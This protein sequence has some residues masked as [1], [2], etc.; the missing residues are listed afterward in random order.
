LK[1]PSEI[2]RVALMVAWIGLSRR[3]AIKIAR[4]KPIIN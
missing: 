1:S 3:E 2:F 4:S